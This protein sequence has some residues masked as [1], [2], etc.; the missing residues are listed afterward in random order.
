MENSEF[1]QEI[2]L[3]EGKK[4]ILIFPGNLNMIDVKVLEHQINIL[5]LSMSI[6]QETGGKKFL[7]ER[8]EKIRQSEEKSQS[9]EKELSEKWSIPTSTGKKKQNEDDIILVL[10]NIGKPV[11][12]G[13]LETEYTK[14]TGDPSPITNISRKMRNERK[15][16][17]ARYN[18]SN[19]AVYWGLPEW[20]EVINGKTQW[21]ENKSPDNPSGKI[22]Y[23][24]VEF[25]DEKNEGAP[26]KKDDA[27][28]VEQ[29]TTD[30]YNGQK[31]RTC[32]KCKETKSVM[33]FE[34]GKK[35]C[36]RCDGLYNRQ[37]KERFQE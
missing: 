4:A 5:K 13:E 33:L 6:D 30:N 32:P 22:D 23:S 26:E 35:M 7:Y 10:K 9:L 3:T 29:G 2:R 12:I 25:S 28:I 11:V 27:Q 16:I 15:L 36:K 14:H 21:I 8:M 34:E 20:T 24:T 31:R 17:T 19:R 1:R 18:N 37:K